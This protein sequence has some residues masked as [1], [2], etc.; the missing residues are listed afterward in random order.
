MEESFVGASWFFGASWPE[1][2]QM[3][4]SAASAAQEALGTY[5]ALYDDGLVRGPYKGLAAAQQNA[6]GVPRQLIALPTAV[7]RRAMFTVLELIALAPD[8]TDHQIGELL[9]HYADATPGTMIKYD[10]RNCCCRERFVQRVRTPSS[11]GE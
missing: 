9:L 11:A 1:M 3:D 5:C 2:Q 7:H 4:R 8:A 6:P 10:F